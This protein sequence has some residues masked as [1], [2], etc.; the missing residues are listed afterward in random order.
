MFS[1][2]FKNTARQT[3]SYSSIYL[4]NLGFRFQS[5]A[6]KHAKP[7]KPATGI[8]KLMQQYG[9]SA[10]GVYLGISL[11]DLPICFV[12]VHSAGED[13]IREIQDGFF[14]WIGYNTD[15]SND[16]NEAA[17]ST[18]ENDGKSSTLVTEFALAYAIHKSLVF[19]RLPLTAAITPWVVKR[20]Q[21]WGFKIGTAAIIKAA[22]KGPKL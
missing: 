10:L 22:N 6:A 21:Q 2:I 13:K 5:T 20:L 19:V 12:V 3:Q 9:Y 15:K 1:N 18:E 17:E 16:D 11:I 8:K 14:S 4:R 7:P